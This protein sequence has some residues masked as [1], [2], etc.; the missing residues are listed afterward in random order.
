[1]K[2]GD[3]RKLPGPEINVTPLIDIV[4]VLLIA[5]I[6]M[7]PSLT[8]SL[9]VSIPGVARADGPPG[10]DP[11]NPPVVISVI[12]DGTRLHYLLQGD[13]FGLSEMAEQLVPMLIRQ[14]AGRRKVH[15]KI[16]GEVPCQ[17]AVEVLDRIHVVSD[18]VQ[19]GALPGA[20]ADGGDVK[21]I[22]SLAS[23]E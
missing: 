7:I 21:I 22:L 18:I 23:P 12:Q 16:G 10:R 13:S 5:F 15:V 8:R 20:Y 3:V 9:P 11:A 6:V 17:A 19:G 1:M 4:L 14:E 2:T